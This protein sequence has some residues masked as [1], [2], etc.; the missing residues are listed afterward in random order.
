MF[1]N[2][3]TYEPLNKIMTVFRLHSYYTNV[4]IEMDLSKGMIEVNDIEKFQ[5]NNF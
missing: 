3:P 2:H 4:N 5:V 1:L